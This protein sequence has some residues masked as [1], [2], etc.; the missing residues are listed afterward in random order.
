MSTLTLS[1]IIVLLLLF[2]AATPAAAQV[3]NAACP[4]GTL[5]FG[6]GDSAGCVKPGTNEVVIKCFYQNT[7]SSGWKGSGVTNDK[8]YELCC[9]PPPPRKQQTLEEM[10]NEHYP[11][12]TCMWDGTAPF[13]KGRCP[14]NLR[15]GQYPS[16]NGK[17]MPPGFG[18]PCATGMKVYCCRFGVY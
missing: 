6:Y 9:P 16:K 14:A 1:G 18:E 5:L 7:C 2:A 11:N 13:C 17:G 3:P 15:D 12:R 10:L 8:G 4:A